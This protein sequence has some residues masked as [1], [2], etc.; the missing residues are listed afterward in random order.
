MHTI[1]DECTKDEFMDVVDDA[2]AIHEEFAEWLD[3]NA[4]DHDVLSLEYI[5]DEDGGII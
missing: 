1:L 4:K 2:H 3:P 5:G